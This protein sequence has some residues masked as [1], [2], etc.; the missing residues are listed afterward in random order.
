MHYV[1]TLNIITSF[2][3]KIIIPTR[4]NIIAIRNRNVHLQV[5]FD[6]K[7]LKECAC[8]RFRKT[9]TPHVI[10]YRKISGFGFQFASFLGGS[11]GFICSSVCWKCDLSFEG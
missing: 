8:I 1:A 5:F 4:I 3:K 6:G 2:S 7:A 11:T 9:Y 10:N